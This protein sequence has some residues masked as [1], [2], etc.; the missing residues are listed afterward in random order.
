MRIEM[1]KGFDIGWDHAIRIPEIKRAQSANRDKILAGGGITRLKVHLGGGNKNVE[2]CL[3]CGKEI[4]DMFR[5][6]IESGIEKRNG[7]NIAQEHYRAVMHAH[8]PGE[9]SDEDD[10]EFEMARQQSRDEYK[11]F[12]E[13]GSWDRRGPTRENSNV[14]ST[15]SSKGKGGG[16]R[17]D[18]SGPSRVGG[19]GPSGFD[20]DHAQVRAS[21]Q[22]RGGG[23]GRGDGSGPS[24][25]GG[26]GPPGFDG[27][28]GVQSQQP[29]V[30]I[31]GGVG[32]QRVTAPRVGPH[33]CPPSGR[34]DAP[35]LGLNKQLVVP[36][37]GRDNRGVYFI[38]RMGLT[39][40]LKTRPW[41]FR[42]RGSLTK[43]RSTKES[44]SYTSTDSGNCFM[45]KGRLIGSRCQVGTQYSRS[46]YYGNWNDPQAYSTTSTYAT[47]SEQ[48]A[49]P[50]SYGDWNAP[51][52]EYSIESTF[53]LPSE[54]YA[55]PRHSYGGWNEKD[56]SMEDVQ[57]FSDHSVDM[58]PPAWGTVWE[59]P[60][61]SVVEETGYPI[62][63]YLQ[64]CGKNLDQSAYDLYVENFL[65]WNQYCN[66]FLFESTLHGV[67][68]IQ[69]GRKSFWQ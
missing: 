67:K 17:G 6:I 57:P 30:S 62:I 49:S 47:S 58:P 7:K 37:K 19:G 11:R 31:G 29:R 64:L 16:G 26:G 20:D 27:N 15:S 52:H 51:S 65:T 14:P 38:E 33:K 18:G 61:R 8:R 36:H 48:Y 55:P 10:N 68:G 5:Q 50:Q 9:D 34:V 12:C 41:C 23:G 54:Q 53:V 35:L 13:T 24:R 59:P 32:S 40:Q 63:G 1:P 44:R 46:Q 66:D 25:V 3:K 4:R 56:Q 60:S 45:G 39:M 21:G 42:Q 43:K 28:D 69:E 22:S 2:K